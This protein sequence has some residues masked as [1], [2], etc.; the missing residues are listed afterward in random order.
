MHKTVV[1]PRQGHQRLP[2][3]GGGGL[4]GRRILACRYPCPDQSILNFS[5]KHFCADKFLLLQH[6]FRKGAGERGS[7]HEFIFWS[8]SN[9]PGKYLR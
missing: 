6:K 8:C 9:L 1:E 2:K 5:Q 7:I 3:T 4:A